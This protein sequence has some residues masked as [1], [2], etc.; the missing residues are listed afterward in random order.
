[1]GSAQLLHTCGE[2]ERPDVD[3]SEE[4]SGLAEKWNRM[5]LQNRMI[6]DAAVEENWRGER[7][8][9][10]CSA[11][12]CTIVHASLFGILRFAMPHFTFCT[13]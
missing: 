3:N 4:S 10:L 13:S 8:S 11:M 5:K 9:M 1:M 7:H 6:Y 12:L 2:Q